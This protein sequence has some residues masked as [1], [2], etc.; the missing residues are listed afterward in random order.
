V[1]GYGYAAPAGISAGA[2]ALA[3]LIREELLRWQAANAAA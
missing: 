2:A 3:A 1:I